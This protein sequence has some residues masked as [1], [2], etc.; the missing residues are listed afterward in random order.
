MD[1]SE[2]AGRSF[3][4]EWSSTYDEDHLSAYF[5]YCHD[6]LFRYMR[7]HNNANI[8]DLGCGTGEAVFKLA[9]NFP[10]NMIF[11]VDLSKEMLKKA[12]EKAEGKKNLLFQVAE[13]KGIPFRSNYFDYI[14]TT[15]SFHH[16]RDPVNALLEI[17]RVLKRGGNFFL[18]D[19]CR[20]KSF[21][22]K[23]WDIYHKIVRKGHVRYYS[24]S[25]IGEFLA[26]AG[27]KDN[28]LLHV[29]K[30]FKKHNKLFFSIQIW[31][32]TKG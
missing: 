28:K 27:F 17:K 9:E 32:G 29:E 1:R 4:D 7:L 3:F 19:V 6:K 18:L 11:G 31:R 5:V 14:F 20:D 12:N 24:T 13:S 8:L 10:D 26:Q 23:L 30:G 22:I 15:N 2:K 16:Y 25:E 21:G